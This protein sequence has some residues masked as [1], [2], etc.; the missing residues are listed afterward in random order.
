MCVSRILRGCGSRTLRG[1]GSRTLRGCGS[2][3]L[4]GWGNRT[5]RGCGSR[6]GSRTLRGCGSRTL[7]GCGSNKLLVRGYVRLGRRSSNRLRIRGH[8]RLGRRH[9]NRLRYRGRSHKR[10]WR[11]WGMRYFR[12]G[13]L[14]QQTSIEVLRM[15]LCMVITTPTNDHPL[16]TTPNNGHP[17]ITTPSNAHPLITTPNNDHLL[18]TRGGYRGGVQ[19]PPLEPLMNIISPH[20]AH[21]NAI[22]CI[23]PYAISS[24]HIHQYACNRTDT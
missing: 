15:E 24:P 20:R 9:Y 21:I 1:W 14:M 22:T 12:R 2:R 19:G 6:W 7:R 18:I 23:V 3:T 16:I 17:L 10:P 8:V 5:L 4:R 11:G 13:Q